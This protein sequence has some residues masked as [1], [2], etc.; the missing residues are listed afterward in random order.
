MQTVLLNILVEIR[1]TKINAS[2]TRD[3]KIKQVFNLNSKLMNMKKDTPEETLS[4][5]LKG[6]FEIQLQ[7]LFDHTELP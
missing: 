7:A 2:P 6:D 3:T 4:I 1:Q 5:F